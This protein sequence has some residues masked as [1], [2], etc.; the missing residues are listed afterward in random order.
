MAGAA[1]LVFGYANAQLEP[2]TK[3]LQSSDTV[4]V[5]VN[6]A[7]SDDEIANK[8]ILHRNTLE[9]GTGK[10][11]NIKRKLYQ[12]PTPQQPNIPRIKTDTTTVRN[13]R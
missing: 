9:S 1:T 7:K 4:V 11:D 6:K 2:K 8:S 12:P 13:K 3:Q 10:P 5:Q